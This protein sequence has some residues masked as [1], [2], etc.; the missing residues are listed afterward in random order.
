MRTQKRRV[1]LRPCEQ[2]H[3]VTGQVWSTD[4]VQ[5][6]ILEVEEAR[7]TWLRAHLSREASTV[8]VQSAWPHSGRQSPKTTISPDLASLQLRLLLLAS[9]LWAGWS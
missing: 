1:G 7:G 9:E 5:G 3:K 4:G 8:G 2:P 6:G